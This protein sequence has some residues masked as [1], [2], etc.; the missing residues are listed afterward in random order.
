M[1]KDIIIAVAIIFTLFLGV[2]FPMGGQTI[3]EKVQSL[4]A[5]TSFSTDNVTNFGGVNVYSY[6][7]PLPSTAASGSTTLATVKSPAATSTLVYA[8][9]N[10]NSATSSASVVT[11]AKGAQPGA[12]TTALTADQP[13]AANTRW[14]MVAGYASSTAFIIAPNQFIN[15]TQAG[16]GGQLFYPGGTCLFRFIAEG[17]N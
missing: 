1:S 12:T 11:L 16:G 8:S 9:C 6:N 2:T 10:P 5:S 15:V 4:G 17:T 7:R 13:Y 3:V 14:Q